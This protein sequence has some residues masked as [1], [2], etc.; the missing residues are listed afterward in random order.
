MNESQKQH[1]LDVADA[2][3]RN[4]SLY[5]QETF[6][7]SCGTPG[8]VAGW[9]R[10]VSAYGKELAEYADLRLAE[11]GIEQVAGDDLGLEHDAERQAVFDPDPYWGERKPTATDAVV[12]LRHLAATGEIRWPSQEDRK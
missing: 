5:R 10:A 12:M 9:S 4:A 7:H 2:I 6:M 1:A 8:C 11:G 3:E